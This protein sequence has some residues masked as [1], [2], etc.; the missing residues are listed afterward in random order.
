[1][2]DGDKNKI[3]N[4]DKDKD[5]NIEL[6]FVSGDDREMVVKVR[7]DTKFSI[8]MDAWFKKTDT[9]PNLQRFMFDGRRIGIDDT[10]SKFEMENGDTIDVLVEQTGGF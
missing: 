9:R 7:S 2:S 10:P 8:I 1:M 4:K 6:R 3:T 5:G